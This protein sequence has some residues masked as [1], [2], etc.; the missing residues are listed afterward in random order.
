MLLRLSGSFADY[1]LH[2]WDRDLEMETGAHA[3]LEQLRPEDEDQALALLR[4]LRTS[5][6]LHGL[7]WLVAEVGSP[8]A[9]RDLLREAARLIARGRIKVWRMT[10]E[11]RGSEAREVFAQVSEPEQVENEIFEGV[12]VIPRIAVE[13]PPTLVVVAEIEPP[14]ELMPAVEIEP[15]PKVVLRCDVV[16]PPPRL[17]S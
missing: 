8:I 9:E 16:A 3:R 2:S 5:G 4:R 14:P 7:R 6:S 1:L 17:G 13:P 10:V 11:P 15:P 12:S